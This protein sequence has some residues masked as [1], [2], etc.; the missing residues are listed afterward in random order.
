MSSVLEHESRMPV[1][2]FDVVSELVL[3]MIAA[4]LLALGTVAFRRR[5]L[6]G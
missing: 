1:A 3:T 6:T 4:A 5:D 2:D